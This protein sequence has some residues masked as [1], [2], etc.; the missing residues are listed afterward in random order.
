MNTDMNQ[1]LIFRKCMGI[2]INY[3]KKMIAYQLKAL[4]WA[5][6]LTI[7]AYRA[8]L[9]ELASERSER[10]TIRGVQIRAGVVYVYICIY[11]G[12]CNK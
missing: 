11:G 8:K 6:S 7:C 9:E 4:C 10:D 3:C 5:S 12:T 2:L 1:Y